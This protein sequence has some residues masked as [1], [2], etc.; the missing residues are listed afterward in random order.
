MESLSHQVS[1]PS[2]VHFSSGQVARN[3]LT[4]YAVR[5]YPGRNPRNAVVSRSIAPEASYVRELARIRLLSREQELILARAVREGDDKSREVM[6]VS[7]LRLVVSMARR[8]RNRGVSLLDL[9]EEGN[10]GLMR[11]VDK[12]DPELGC[13]F[14]TYATWWVRQS[15]ERAIMNHARDVRLPVHIIKDISQCLRR[16]NVLAHELGRLPTR[17]ELA[18]ACDRDSEELGTLLG[19]HESSHEYQ[20]F[21]PE[22]EEIAGD[23]LASAT[24][25]DPANHVHR[26]TLYTTLHGWLADLSARQRDVLTLRFGLDG[27]PAR[28]L[29]EVG[30]SV[31]L[32]RERVRQIQLQAISRLHQFARREGYD[33]SAFF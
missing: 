13:R 25:I 16:Q 21:M 15:V 8:Y 31:G 33:I 22:V 28:T 17:A 3:A 5:L 1:A 7:N 23:E 6:I 2:A 9:I 27:Q 24:N 18:E 4:D 14:S 12:Y 29:E 30:E 19:R 20:D 26:A 32:T 10:I 11:A